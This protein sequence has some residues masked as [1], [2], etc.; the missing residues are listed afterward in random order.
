MKKSKECYGC[1]GHFNMF[2]HETA[3][4]CPIPYKFKLNNHTYECPC[5]LCLV[6]A[7]CN[8]SCSLVRAYNTKYD[9]YAKDYMNDHITKEF[10]K[11]VYR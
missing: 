6:K 7:M 4:D 9:T 8:N 1:K 5:V 10:E 2:F 11:G 3:I